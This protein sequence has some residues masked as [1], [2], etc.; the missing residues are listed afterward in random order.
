M[1]NNHDWIFKNKLFIAIILA[2][3]SFTLASAYF[4][5]L[6]IIAPE[7]IGA[8]SLLV[9]KLLLLDLILILILMI[10][11]TRKVYALW[12]ES[13]NNGAPAKLQKRIVLTFSLIAVI[14][15]LLVAVFSTVFFNFGIQSWFN[16]KISMALKESV[17]IAKLSIDEHQKLIKSDAEALAINVSYIISNFNLSDVEDL[18]NYLTKQANDRLLAE[19]VLFTE[20]PF[21][22]IARSSFSLPLVPGS[23]PTKL[24]AGNNQTVIIPQEDRVRAL[25]KVNNNNLYLLVSRF[26]DPKL[27]RHLQDAQS[28]TGEFNNLKAEMDN[29]QTRFSLVFIIVSMILLIISTFVGIYYSSYLTS[30]ILE[31]VKATENIRRGNYS[32]RVDVTNEEDEISTLGRS[33]NHMVE[34]IQQQRDELIDASMQIDN[35]RIFIEAIVSGV[36]AGIVALNKSL[37]ISLINKQACKTLDCKEEEVEGIALADVCVEM[38]D[39]LAKLAQSDIVHGDIK[40]DRN[41][42]ISILHVKVI[43]ELQNEVTI[44]YIVTF[45]DITALV[46]AERTAAWTDVARKIAH[47]IKNPLTPINLATNRLTSKY[48]DEVKDK[49]NFKRYTSTISRHVNEIGSMVEEFIKYA[50]LP[51]PKFGE[52][53]VIKII[54]DCVNLRKEADN[55]IDIFFTTK[56]DEIVIKCDKAQIGQ[57]VTNLVKNAEESILDRSNLDVV[58]GKIEVSVEQCKNNV[59]LNVKDNGEGFNKEI[60]ERLTMPYV[61]SKSYGTGLGLAIVKK[62]LDDHGAE[63]EF[64]NNR[65]IGAFVRVIFR[66]EEV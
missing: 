19:V 37:Q 2:L 21:E 22:V 63:I 43:K 52:Y 54:K 34:R 66:S 49:E 7:S 13:R 10:S 33:F 51:S 4:T 8:D 45:D 57:V 12:I 9:T 32:F 24:L 35:R 64:G 28:T 14:P 31:L 58:P 20:K 61:T 36:S 40:I 1:I 59:I 25:V 44:G 38:R 47:E 15:T 55:N 5:Y 6:A 23:I 11:I 50:K 53:N 18:N 56:I 16:N 42:K 3:I 17:E 62:I 30:P 27:I 39:L 60:F 26:I 29:I 41:G 46:R 65:D 48:L